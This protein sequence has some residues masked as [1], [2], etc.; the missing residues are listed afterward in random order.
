[1]IDARTG[2]ITQTSLERAI[3]SPAPD[4]RRFTALFWQGPPEKQWLGLYAVP[5]GEPLYREDH[6]RPGHTIQAWSPDGKW[7]VRSPWRAKQSVL[8][9]VRTADGP[10]KEIALG[11]LPGD[12]QDGNR[13]PA[14]WS[15]A[16][17]GKPGLVAAG[18]G[19]SHMGMVILNDLASGARLAVLDGFPIWVQ[20]VC[21]VG[22]GRLLT[23]TYGGR[24]QLWDLKEKKPLWTTDTKE[25]VI[26][27]GLVRGGPY[28]VCV[29][30]YRS[31]SLVR[32]ED[33]TVVRRTPRLLGS[34]SS[35]K[36]PWVYP[37]LLGNG[38]L[39]LEMAPDAMQLQLVD[40]ATGAARL[41]L[42]AMPED[43]WIVYTPEGAWD[44]SPGIH[45]WVKFYRG[46]ESLAPTEADRHRSRVK[47]E[48]AVHTVFGDAKHDVSMR[49][50][51]ATR[52]RGSS[53]GS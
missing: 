25:E 40:V 14:L 16:V 35:A 7:L 33:G 3:T 42:C 36:L 41:T 52:D 15:L 34:D 9:A 48:T 31:A 39:A 22:P 2:A 12:P 28:A 4:G 23:G 13:P 38:T 5:P 21:F 10:A 17:D 27:F 20:S 32:L 47:I 50:S 37:A 24:V 26:Q 11:D 8:H 1:M 18:L 44:G 29:H 51:A 43:Q 30:L 53:S 45:A 19:S 49:S 6:A 46:F